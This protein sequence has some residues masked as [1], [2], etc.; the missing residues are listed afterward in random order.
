MLQVYFIPGEQMDE[1]TKETKS[2]FGF[3]L[4]I[5][6]VI[7][8]VG[9]LI[10]MASVF[11]QFVPISE[12]SWSLLGRGN[13]V[14]LFALF[15]GIA[16]LTRHYFGAFFAGMFSAYFLTHEIIIEYEKK[17]IAALQE[18]EPDGLYRLVFSVYADAFSIKT[19]AFWSLLGVIV[20][21]LACIV[22]W[23]IN[24]LRSNSE[25]LEAAIIAEEDVDN[26]GSED[27]DEDGSFLDQSELLEEKI[28]SE[29]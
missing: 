3:E 5:A 28:V 20:A 6:E 17:A 7:S 21:L 24:T 18:V 8:A 4:G 1:Y 11:M 9:F 16:V 13:A 26:E 22:G 2:G 14:F 25:M 29:S 23:V 12:Q 15:G 27:N 19:G 10:L